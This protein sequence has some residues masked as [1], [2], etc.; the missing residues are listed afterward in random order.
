VL[1]EVGDGDE[2]V[3]NPHVGGDVEE[4]DSSPAKHTC[5]EV[6][7]ITHNGQAEIGQ[8]NVDGFAGTETALVGSKWSRAASRQS[9]AAC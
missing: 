5:G 6:D 7:G 4:K 8:G 2:P 9:G 1:V 3:M